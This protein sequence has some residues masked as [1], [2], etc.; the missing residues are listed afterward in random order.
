[1]PALTSVTQTPALKLLT[2]QARVAMTT[3][4]MSS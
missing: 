4:V 3:G 1:M 2:A